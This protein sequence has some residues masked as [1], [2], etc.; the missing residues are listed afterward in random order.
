MIPVRGAAVLAALQAL[1]TSKTLKSAAL[2]WN[3][4]LGEFF[5]LVVVKEDSEISLLN[6]AR[7]NSSLH[8]IHI[9]RILKGGVVI[10]LIFPS[11][12]LPLNTPPLRS[13]CPFTQMKVVKSQAL[14]NQGL[15]DYESAI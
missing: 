5:L 3:G 10:L 8:S 1:T 14:S 2:G 13:W 7:L 6:P 9:N 4:V 12:P 11:Y 15:R